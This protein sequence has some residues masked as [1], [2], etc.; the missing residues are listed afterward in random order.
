MSRKTD[1][2]LAFSGYCLPWKYRKEFYDNLKSCSSLFLKARER[3]PNNK[4]RTNIFRTKN[5]DN[6][7]SDNNPLKTR[8]SAFKPRAKASAETSESTQTSSVNNFDR[9]IISKNRE[10]SSEKPSNTVR[11]WEIIIFISIQSL[12]F[13]FWVAMKCT[14]MIS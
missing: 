6:R 2:D 5:N 14:S 13:L 8:I 1:F 7:K 12:T 11:E 3:K 9:D 4:I 10:S